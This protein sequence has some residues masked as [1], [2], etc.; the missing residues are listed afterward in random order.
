MTTL[1][2]NSNGRDLPP[3]RINRTSSSYEASC[4]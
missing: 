3:I 4:L 2:E 1:V